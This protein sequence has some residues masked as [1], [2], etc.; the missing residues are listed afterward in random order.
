MRHCATY[1][2]SEVI[3]KRPDDEFDRAL[4][5]LD[6]LMPL[7]PLARAAR[8]ERLREQDPALEQRVATLLRYADEPENRVRE[9]ERLA[10]RELHRVIS[11]IGLGDAPAPIEDEAERL[12]RLAEVRAGL[13]V[14]VG[15]GARYAIE[16]EPLGEGGMGTVFRGSDLLLGR[17]VAIKV[18]RNRLAEMRS[19]DAI[20][21]VEEARLTAQLDHPSIVPLHDVVL[22]ADDRIVLVMKLLD[23]P[24][25][26]LRDEIADSLNVDARVRLG[27]FLPAVIAIAD[28]VAFAHGRGVLHRDLKPD[29]V[30]LGSRGETYVVDW[31]IAQ[32]FRDAEAEG[33]TLPVASARFGGVAGEGFATGDGELPG[34]P[35]YTPPERVLPAPPPASPRTDVY[36]LGAILYTIAAGMP[37]FGDQ[38]VP[39]AGFRR[40]LQD[41]APT[42]VRRLA[43]TVPH[44]IESIIDKA[45]SKRPEDRYASVDAFASD[46]RAFVAGQVVSAHSTSVWQVLK[47]ALYRRRRQVLLIAAIAVAAIA[48]LTY[49]AWQAQTKARLD[50]ADKD[51]ETGRDQAA[52]GF[53]EEAVR[54]YKA[55]LAA[56]HPEAVA[57]QLDL[58]ETYD[59]MALTTEAQQLLEHLS[60]MSPDELGDQ[61]A[62]MLLYR[63]DRSREPWGKLVVGTDALPLVKEALEVG[64]LSSP[65]EHYAR[66]LIAGTVNEAMAEIAEALRV[67]PAHRRAQEM[68][69]SLLLIPIGDRPEAYQVARALR[70][71]RPTDPSAQLLELACRTFV[72]LRLP[73]D[74]KSQYPLVGDRAVAGVSM[75][76]LVMRMVSESQATVASLLA[77]SLVEP[78]AEQDAE[79]YAEL[80]WRYSR[81]VSWAFLGGPDP[82]TEAYARLPPRVSTAWTRC[83]VGTLVA[84]STNRSGSAVEQTKAELAD[85]IAGGGGS[86]VYFMRSVCNAVLGDTEGAYADLYES[87][88]RPSVMPIKRTCEVGVIARHVGRPVAEVAREALAI[89]DRLP[90]EYELTSDEYQL[91]WQ[92][93]F[94]IDREC[95]RREIGARW[96]RLYPQDPAARLADAQDV[97]RVAPDVAVDRMRAILA[98]HP[99]HGPTQELLEQIE[100]LRR[101]ASKG[102]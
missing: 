85:F 57:I 29:N 25:R 37:P 76:L 30:M 61:R 21:F 60:Q 83:A 38:A 50:Q 73:D 87:A 26:T 32:A 101:P 93:Y 40:V 71:S 53:G 100:R 54:F 82:Q 80:L 64:G 89:A 78:D 35:G 20:R 59:S 43:V 79:A 99:D 49:S 62:R 6:E 34:S 74:I 97:Y 96:L 55:A 27:R 5:L 86:L 2:K 39:A 90:I 58:A 9:T 63:G 12:R 3:V 24:A 51:W 14:L 48:A 23:A 28:A 11:A 13:M 36:G 75:F 92:F 1:S 94:G 69:A 31:G 66:A 67:D 4:R 18:T 52:V 65:D 10:L 44:E 42:P 70:L 81:T 95:Q 102:G 77:R 56:G 88:M 33:D 41:G 47:K 22:D 68:R 84:M 19:A 91:L 46:L 17:A 45:M 16:G 98:D 8:L 15:P 72:D 7:A